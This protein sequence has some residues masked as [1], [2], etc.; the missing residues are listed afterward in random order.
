MGEIALEPVVQEF[1]DATAKPPLLYEL[2]VEG[3]RKLIQDPGLDCGDRVDHP[4]AAAGRG[5]RL[6]ATERHCERKATDRNIPSQTKV[7][8]AE[9]AKA[10]VVSV[11]ASHAVSVSRLGE[12]ARLINE[13]AQE[14]A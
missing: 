13:A 5:H 2:G 3:A 4:R 1:A 8:M 11:T 12:V 10:T 7:F 6:T 14:S 9:R